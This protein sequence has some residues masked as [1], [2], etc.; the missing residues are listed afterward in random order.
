MS[1]FGALTITKLAPDRAHA[2]LPAHPAAVDELDL[3]VARKGLG[4][5]R[6]AS[7]VPAIVAGVLACRAEALGRAWQAV[8]WRQP[9][10]RRLGEVLGVALAGQ[11]HVRVYAACTAPTCSI[12]Q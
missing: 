12:K 6:Q 4:V 1:Q 5:G 3:A 7:S 8:G 10:W 2:V 9:C 11:V